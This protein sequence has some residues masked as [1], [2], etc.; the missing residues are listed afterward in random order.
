MYNIYCIYC[1]TCCIYIIYISLY[2]WMHLYCFVVLVCNLCLLICCVSK[3]SL[4][5]GTHNCMRKSNP[6]KNPGWVVDKKFAATWTHHPN[7]KL[8][9]AK[10]AELNR[11][12]YT[13]LQ[14]ALYE[15]SSISSSE[16]LPKKPF[17]A[18]FQIFRNRHVQKTRDCNWTV[19]DRSKI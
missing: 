18:R 19:E 8:F 9:F 16:K 4:Q 17:F 7:S 13:W 12:S 10:C 11:Q 5:M 6:T 14:T 3:C 1:N 15:T 2:I